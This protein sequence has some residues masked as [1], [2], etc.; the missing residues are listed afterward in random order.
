MDALVERLL[1]GCFDRREPV[2]QHRRQN[3]DHL[4][5]AVRRT[6]QFAANPIE[7]RRQ[8][9]IL[10]WRAV[11]Q[12]AGLAGEHRH[13]MPGIEHRLVA[14]KTARMFADELSVLA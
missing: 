13:V 11:A 7:P 9:P 8:N 12:C 14:A 4:S 1:A 2:G 10:E 6:R 3:A 5:V